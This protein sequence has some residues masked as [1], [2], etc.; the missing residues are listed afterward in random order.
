[1]ALAA[2]RRGRRVAD[3]M[4]CGLNAAMASKVL[5]AVQSGDDS[6]ATCGSLVCA[7]MR[8]LMVQQPVHTEP[9]VLRG[10]LISVAT[11]R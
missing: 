6:I 7:G 1:M 5:H 2:Q 8:L 10:A 4:N 3:P 11:P 9:G